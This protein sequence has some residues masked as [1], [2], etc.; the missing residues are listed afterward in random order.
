M[1]P[2]NLAEYWAMDSSLGNLVRY[3]ISGYFKAPFYYDDQGM[4]VFCFH[5]AHTDIDGKNQ[6]NSQKVKKKRK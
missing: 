3:D 2:T 5:V 4:A 1:Y 6:K